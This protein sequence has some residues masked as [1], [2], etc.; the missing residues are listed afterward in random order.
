MPLKPES[1]ATRIKGISDEAQGKAQNIGMQVNM[2]GE[3]S[4]A[5]HNQVKYF[6]DQLQQRG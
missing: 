2:M 6:V 4:E 3:S 1:S 5:L